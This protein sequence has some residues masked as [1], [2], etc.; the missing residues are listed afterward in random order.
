MKDWIKKLAN[1]QNLSNEDVERLDQ[2]LQAQDAAGLQ[3]V[4]GS[5]PRHEAPESIVRAFDASI[6]RRGLLRIAS[7]FGAFAAA[8]MAMFFALNSTKTQQPIA[9]TRA[10]ADSLYDWHAEAAAASVLPSDSASLAAFSQVARG[11]NQ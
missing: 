2:A 10:T 7:G 8:S 1:E 11:E 9:E 3:S 6:K 5:L 4:V